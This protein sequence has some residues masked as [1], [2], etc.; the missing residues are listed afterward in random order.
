MARLKKW[1]LRLKF[2]SISDEALPH[3]IRR[4]WNSTRKCI[5]KLVIPLL[6]PRTPGLP[7][8]TV[9]PIFPRLVEDD[10]LT[11]PPLTTP[12]PT[13]IGWFLVAANTILNPASPRWRPIPIAVALATP[14]IRPKCPGPNPPWPAPCFENP[15]PTCPRHPDPPQRALKPT[16]L[17]IRYTVTPDTAPLS[18]AR[19]LKVMLAL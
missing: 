13:P 18:D 17:L 4:W 14:I 1:F 16:R 8:R 19:L 9:I 7:A 10:S 15:R 3:D 12:H 6:V 5:A 11:A 2:G